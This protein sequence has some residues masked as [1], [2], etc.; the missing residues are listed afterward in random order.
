MYL[1][2]D[3]WCMKNILLLLICPQCKVAVRCCIFS[4]QLPSERT[5]HIP[6]FSTWAFKCVS[7]PF[8][9]TDDLH[10]R[11][12]SCYRKLSFFLPIYL[13]TIPFPIN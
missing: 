11:S 1:K 2:V 10:L 12:S 8:W 3:A 4:T 6:A 7:K 13:F 9:G 5:I